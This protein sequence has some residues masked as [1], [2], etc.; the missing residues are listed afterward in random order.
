MSET[1]KIAFQ[2]DMEGPDGVLLQILSRPV[3]TQPSI[4]IGQYYRFGPGNPIVRLKTMS[5]DVWRRIYT[6]ET[7]DGGEAPY[8]TDTLMERMKSGHLEEI[9]PV[10]WPVS[11]MRDTLL[12]IVAHAAYCH[13]ATIESE[14]LLSRPDRARLARDAE[15][16]RT[17]LALLESPPEGRAGIETL[18]RAIT[19]ALVHEAQTIR[20][21]E[22]RPKPPATKI[23]RHKEIASSLEVA[24]A[25]LSPPRSPGLERTL[26]RLREALRT[27]DAVPAPR[28]PQAR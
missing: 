18:E 12:A 24:R 17:L 6:F 20:T 21:Y 4:A 26:D 1:S 22:A 15:H 3:Q 7:A 9:R 28:A 5:P 14:A 19:A 23:R 25:A 13:A 2:D 8:E 16:G 27:A 11:R 10:V